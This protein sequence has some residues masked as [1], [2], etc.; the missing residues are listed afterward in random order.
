MAAHIGRLP[1]TDELVHHINEDTTD[2]RIENLQIVTRAEHS[3]IHASSRSAETRAR[4]SA[5]V[6]RAYAEGRKQ[7][8]RTTLTW[9]D[10]RE[11]RRLLAEGVS[12]RAVA[13]RWGISRD[14]VYNI[15]DG[16]RWREADS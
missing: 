12:V 4:L 8:P 9:D 16:K 6:R 3:R 7:R 10:V 11:M 5:G 13:I 1:R 2:D 15:R 14:S